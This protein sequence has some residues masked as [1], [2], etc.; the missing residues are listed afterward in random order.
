[1]HYGN[2]AQ[3]VN[4]DLKVNPGKGQIVRDKEASS[5]MA[6]PLTRKGWAI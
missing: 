4:R 1:M 5:W 2:I 3:K 6:G